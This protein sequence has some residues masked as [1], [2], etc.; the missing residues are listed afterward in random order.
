MYRFNGKYKISKIKVDLYSMLIVS[1][2]EI[3]PN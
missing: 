3:N 2:E 1:A